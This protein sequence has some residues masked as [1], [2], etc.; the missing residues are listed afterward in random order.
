MKKKVFITL[1][2]AM[3]FQFGLAQNTRF[4]VGLEGGPSYK[5]MKYNRDFSYPGIGFSTGVFIQYNAKKLFSVRF[6]PCYERKGFW[7]DHYYNFNYIVLPLLFRLEYGG[8]FRGF[9]GTGPFVGYLVDGYISQGSASYSPSL[10]DYFKNFNHFDAGISA[11]VGV[12]ITI[13]QKVSVSFE[14]RHNFGLYQIV[15]SDISEEYHWYY[16]TY[17]SNF[18]TSISYN[19]STRKAN[20]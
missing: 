16:S 14:V 17:S 2:L 3:V 12:I 15:K 5:G 10:R 8:K 4:S 1:F 18:L 9:V 6:A 7:N 19:F 13:L 11:G 20:K